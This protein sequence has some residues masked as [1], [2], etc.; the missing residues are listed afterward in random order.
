ML[1]DNSEEIKSSFGD[2]HF[3]PLFVFLM[4]IGIAGAIRMKLSYEEPEQV[5]FED[6]IFEL[7]YESEASV[8]MQ[9]LAS[10]NGT[11]YYPIGCKAAN[12]I[13]EE[14]RVYFTSAE[15]ASGAGYGP[16]ANC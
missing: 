8:K 9:F 12:R 15:E 1:E 11:K 3:L 2:R 16:A 7:S 5:R 14:N 4:V 13:L 10:V 6:N